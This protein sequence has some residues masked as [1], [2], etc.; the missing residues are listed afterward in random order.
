MTHENQTNA[1]AKNLKMTKNLLGLFS[2]VDEC[3]ANPCKNGA[4]CTNT[5]GDYK[6]T[7][8]NRFTGKNC[9]QGSLHFNT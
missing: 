6:C 2:D 4:K 8:D 1:I 3:A 7:C 5:H 9:D